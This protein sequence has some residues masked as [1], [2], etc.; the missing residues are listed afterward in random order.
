MVSRVQLAVALV[1]AC[2]VTGCRQRPGGGSLASPPAVFVSR[3]GNFKVSIRGTP[4]EQRQV[5]PHGTAI[6]YYL[7][8]SGG[9][10]FSVAYSDHPKA[11][12]DTE[13]GLQKMIDVFLDGYLPKM[14][15]KVTDSSR[16]KI[17][18]SHVGRDFRADTTVIPSGKLRGRMFFIGQRLYRLE[19]VGTREVVEGQEANR[20]FQT[21]EVLK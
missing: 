18:G 15:A 5:T 8:E 11:A 6:F 2:S 7:W 1:L 20:F 4:A 21:F 17:G 19:V 9:R 13:E 14:K 3:D 16:G 10:L 12:T